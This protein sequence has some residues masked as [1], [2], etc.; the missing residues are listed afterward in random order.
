MS[1]RGVIDRDRN[2]TWWFRLDVAPAGAPRKQVRRRGFRTKRDAQAALNE[3]LHDVGKGTFVATERI[4]VA[5]YLTS[6][7]TPDTR[8]G[9]HR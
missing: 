1:R 4:T 6:G 7:G 9:V 2:G 8:P 5:E 3:V